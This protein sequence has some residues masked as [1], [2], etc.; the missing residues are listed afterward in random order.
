MSK[1][2]VCYYL[3]SIFLNL[4]DEILIFN[5]VVDICVYVCVHGYVSLGHLD[6]WGELATCKRSPTVPVLK[7]SRCPMHACVYAV[8]VCIVGG[9]GGIK[10]KGW[11]VYVTGL[12]SFLLFRSFGMLSASVLCTCIFMYTQVHTRGIS[13]QMIISLCL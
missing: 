12:G 10:G 8:Y 11:F 4:G 7:A 5:Q 2:R 13:I 1:P 6:V 9:G 3:V